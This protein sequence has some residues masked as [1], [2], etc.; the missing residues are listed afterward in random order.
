MR[1]R[2]RA[3]DVSPN[4]TPEGACASAALRESLH[5]RSTSTADLQTEVAHRTRER[6]EALEQQ[7]ATSEVLNVI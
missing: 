7:A 3:G 2:S 5:H 1:R 4:A 6:D